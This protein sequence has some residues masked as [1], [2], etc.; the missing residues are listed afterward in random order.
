MCIRDRRGAVNVNK[1]GGVSLRRAYAERQSVLV[2]ASSE[3]VDERHDDSPELTA[4]RAAAAAAVVV[5]PRVAEL[6][7]DA[8]WCTDLAYIKYSHRLLTSHHDS[9]SV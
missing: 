6:V 2:G 8:I 1:R 3:R 5:A 9:R 7:R 4:A